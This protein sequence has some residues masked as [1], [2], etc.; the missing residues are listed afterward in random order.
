MRRWCNQ[1]AGRLLQHGLGKGPTQARRPKGYHRTIRWDPCY[2]VSGFHEECIALYEGS[3]LA[4]QGTLAVLHVCGQVRSA[5]LVLSICTSY[6]EAPDVAA[7]LP[8][9]II[10]QTQ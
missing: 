9:I 4:V 8:S 1:G 10:L 3:R 2:Q 6:W 5:T 7:E